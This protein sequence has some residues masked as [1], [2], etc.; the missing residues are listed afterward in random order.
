MVSET[1]NPCRSIS[2]HGVDVLC[3]LCSLTN[4]IKCKQRLRI[5][6]SLT[7]A[8]LS[9]DSPHFFTHQRYALENDLQPTFSHTNHKLL[10][11]QPI[12]EHQHRGLSPRSRGENRVS[13]FQCA[14]AHFSLPIRTWAVPRLFFFFF[15][16]LYFYSFN[17]NDD[18]GS[19]AMIRN[20]SW[21]VISCLRGP[22]S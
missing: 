21:K 18:D 20:I 17:T 22:V 1:P 4:T 9:L 19:W 2:M 12:N 10:S 15:L 3:D 16:R 13:I 7:K 11:I 6:C 14:Y 5:F 8:T